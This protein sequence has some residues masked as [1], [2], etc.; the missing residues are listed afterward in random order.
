MSILSQLI[1]EENDK[2]KHE[3]NVADN[4]DIDAKKWLIL[5][6]R[7]FQ[8]DQSLEAVQQLIF[9]QHMLHVKYDCS[10]RDK[11]YKDPSSLTRHHFRNIYSNKAQ[12][13]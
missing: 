2:H 11:Q 5:S 9:N 6:I 13:N 7:R 4:V 3:N 1:T 10:Q 12:L 8:A